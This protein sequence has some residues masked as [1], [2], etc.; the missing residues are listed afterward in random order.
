[1]VDRLVWELN[2]PLTAARMLG[3]SD[4]ELPLHDDLLNQPLEDF[5]KG[6][7]VAVLCD[8]CEVITLNPLMVMVQSEMH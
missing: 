6:D 3:A 1:M 5:Q 7:K 8:G 2:C 4:E